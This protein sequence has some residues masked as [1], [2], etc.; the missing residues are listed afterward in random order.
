MF[1]VTE[2]HSMDGSP[3]R[4]QPSGNTARPFLLDEARFRRGYLLPV[5]RPGHYHRSPVRLRARQAAVDCFFFAQELED[6]ADRYD[7]RDQT[8]P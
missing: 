7:D 6:G 1:A 4:T 5:D 2:R 3:A 8:G